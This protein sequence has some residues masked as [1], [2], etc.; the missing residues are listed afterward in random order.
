MIASC[1]FMYV[2]VC[3]VCVRVRVHLVPA[4]P[5][6]RVHTHAPELSAYW[7]NA[8]L[9][10]MKA[11]ATEEHNVELLVQLKDKISTDLNWTRTIKSQYVCV[12][13]ECWE[14]YTSEFLTLRVGVRLDSPQNAKP[15]YISTRAGIAL[16]TARRIV[17]T[18]L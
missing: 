14:A 4:P 3:C 2:Y 8:L 5:H 18:S 17:T 10:S 1:V 13:I 11:V 7:A 6:Q 9:T 15:N 12:W 16:A